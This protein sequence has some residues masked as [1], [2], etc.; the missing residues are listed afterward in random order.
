MR[1]NIIEEIP[2]KISMRRSMLKIYGG[3]IDNVWTDTVGH[4]EQIFKRSRNAGTV[5]RKDF[6]INSRK[7]YKPW[8][9]ERG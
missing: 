1:R 9:Y 5:T 7:N 2:V 3:C 6:R 8:Q 4:L